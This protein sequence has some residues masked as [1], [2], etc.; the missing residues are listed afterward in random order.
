V[1]KRRLRW[2][3]VVRPH[4]EATVR[5]A[6]SRRVRLLPVVPPIRRGLGLPVATARAVLDPPPVAIALSSPSC[7][8]HAADLRPAAGHAHAAA[9]GVVPT[10]PVVRTAPASD[11]GLRAPRALRR[12]F[13]RPLGPPFLEDRSPESDLLFL[14]SSASMGAAARAE[15]ALVAHALEGEAGRLVARIRD[16]AFGRAPIDGFWGDSASVDAL[17]LRLCR[18]GLFATAGLG[19]EGFYWWAG[20]RLGP[21]ELGRMPPELLA[22]AAAAVAATHGYRRAFELLAT[23]AASSDPGGE[24]HRLARLLALRCALSGVFLPGLVRFVLPPAAHRLAEPAPAAAWE[25]AMLALHAYRLA[26][27]EAGT[28][29]VAAAIVATVVRDQIGRIARRS[30]PAYR[31]REWGAPPLTPEGE[32]EHRQVVT[33]VGVLLTQLWWT[34]KQP[35]PDGWGAPDAIKVERRVSKALGESGGPAH[36]VYMDDSLAVAACQ[37]LLGHTPSARATLASTRASEVFLPARD[38]LSRAMARG[39]FEAAAPLVETALARDFQGLLERLRNTVDPAEFGSPDWRRLLLRGRLLSRLQRRGP[40]GLALALRTLLGPAFADLDRFWLAPS[41]PRGAN[42]A[43]LAAWLDRQAPVA[44]SDRD[45]ILFLDERCQP[46][47]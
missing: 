32:A 33:L 10:V 19:W 41:T 44:P 30:L 45:F 43:S 8:A 24:A 15:Q 40:R 22:D 27:H 31:P 20:P 14:L 38:R 18:N 23:L 12:V 6:G 37:A 4:P 39:A 5:G 3:T 26:G 11:L 46:N 28:T 17:R 29:H 13:A 42:L 25:P 34:Y 16:L 35:W 7:L 21:E 2:K 36:D 47:A 9:V 1:H